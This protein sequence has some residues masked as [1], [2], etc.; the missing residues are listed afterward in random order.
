MRRRCAPHWTRTRPARRLGAGLALAAG[1]SL[2]LPA[3]AAASADGAAPDLLGTWFVIV[4]YRDSATNNPDAER[5]EDKVWVFE[6]KGSRLQWTEY[7]IVVFDDA[8]GRFEDVGGHRARTLSFWE[9]NDAQLAQ[10]AEGPRVNSRGSKSKTLRGSPEKGF[11]S[12]GQMRAMSASVIGYHETWSIGDP[13]GLPVFTR[14]DVL[15]TGRAAQAGGDKQ[16]MEGRTRYTTEEVLVEGKLLRGSYARD[17]NR[18]GSFQM[19]RAGPA[20]GL[21]TDGPT[22]N[23]K[24]RQRVEEEIRKEMERRLKEADPETIREIREELERQRDNR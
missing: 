3:V 6:E 14:D 24:A 11:E 12:F 22:P 23:E 15:G 10:I 7:P 16:N 18:R 21:P 2:A 20:Q 4:H 8:S 19:L 9:P 13:T 17:E 1:L 5:W